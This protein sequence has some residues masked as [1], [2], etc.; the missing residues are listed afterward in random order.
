MSVIVELFVF[1]GQRSD[2]QTLCVSAAKIS[3]RHPKEL[4]YT[5]V[6]AQN[7]KHEVITNLQYK[8]G[9]IVENLILFSKMIW[10]LLTQI[11]YAF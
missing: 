6:F 10:L 2:N 11:K 9:N 7:H 4:K 3:Q 5:A 8:D 1:F